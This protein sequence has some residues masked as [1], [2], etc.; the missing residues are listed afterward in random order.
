MARTESKTTRADLR[1]IMAEWTRT[2]I[3]YILKC[4]HLTYGADVGPVAGLNG[5]VILD[6]TTIIDDNVRDT[7]F[8]EQGQDYFL[9]GIEDRTDWRLGELLTV[10]EADFLL[11]I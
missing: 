8:G 11:T 6:E 7:V 4:L 1:A 3:S 9:V 5:D 2:D 10:V